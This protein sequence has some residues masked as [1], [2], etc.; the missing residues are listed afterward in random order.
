MEFIDIDEFILDTEF[1]KKYF[2]G[3]KFPIPQRFENETI[4]HRAYRFSNYHRL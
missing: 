1:R 2:Y 3:K 4:T